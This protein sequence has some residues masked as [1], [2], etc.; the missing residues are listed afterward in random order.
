MALTAAALHASIARAQEDTK[1]APTIQDKEAYYTDILEHRVKDIMDALNL[2]DTNKIARVRT[3][4]LLQYRSLRLRD[5]FI[6]AKLAAQDKHAE[7]KAREAL[8]QDLSQPLHQ[9]FVNA[10]ATD[11]T[12]E[13]LEK[14]KDKMTYNK[15]KVT[16]DAYCEIV[17][18]LTDQDK[19]KILE[20]LK[21]AREEAMDGG[22]AGEKS[23]VFKVY[24]GR[25][26]NY[27]DANG[28]DVAQAYK[29]W[30]AKHPQKPQQEASAD[31]TNPP[32]AV[33]Q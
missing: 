4:L 13:Q 21:A 22:S 6:Q 28:H 32:K 18:N 17:P 7:A 25:I 9:W 24:K 29:A 11:L 15:V 27:L 8:L 30:G 31:A 16:Y 14:V 33:T 5:E 2:S 19:A 26:N 3:A 23:A 12:P 1:P 10:L 20:M